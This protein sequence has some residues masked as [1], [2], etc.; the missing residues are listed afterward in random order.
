MYLAVVYSES[1][2]CY[3]SAGPGNCKQLRLV[4]V[5]RDWSVIVEHMAI[6]LL[7]VLRN[8]CS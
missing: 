1:V 7:P 2:L 3:W 5:H 8:C 6:T 4:D